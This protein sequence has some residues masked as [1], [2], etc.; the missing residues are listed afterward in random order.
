VQTHTVHHHDVVGHS[1]VR[2]DA[3]D[4]RQP[5][6]RQ[7]NWLGRLSQPS[8]NQRKQPPRGDTQ[9]DRSASAHHPV[10]GVGHTRHSLALNTNHLAPDR[11]DV[12]AIQ[13]GIQ[14]AALPIDRGLDKKTMR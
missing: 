9:I 7:R 13:P 4:D 8:E 14:A 11:N 12:A 5:G 10:W 6:F 1:Q 2:P 3:A